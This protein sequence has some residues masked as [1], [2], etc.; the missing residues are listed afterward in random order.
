LPAPS[1]LT[2]AEWQAA[3][4]GLPAF[5]GTT[6]RSFHQGLARRATRLALRGENPASVKDLFRFAVR[7]S[8]GRPASAIVGLVREAE[9]GLPLPGKEVLAV[10]ASGT[11]GDEVKSFALTGPDG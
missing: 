10:L 2:D 3:A 5:L 4:S 9:G 11:G 6:W 1:G 7:E 8:L